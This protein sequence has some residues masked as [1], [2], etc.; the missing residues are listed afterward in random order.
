MPLLLAIKFV[1]VAESADQLLPK[2]VSV[3][4]GSVPHALS[5]SFVSKF[6]ACSKH[7]S[8]RAHKS[9]RFC[10]KRSD[11]FVKIMGFACRNYAWLESASHTFNGQLDFERVWIWIGPVLQHQRSHLIAK[12]GNNFAHDFWGFSAR[13]ALNLQWL[14]VDAT[15]QHHKFL[16]KSQLAYSILP[17]F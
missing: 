10:S 9:R 12:C 5:S 17:S 8:A 2:L 4:F 6:D 1:S 15:K 13:T 7:R 3:I 11:L 14:S 16:F